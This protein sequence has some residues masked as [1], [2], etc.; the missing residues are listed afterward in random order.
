MQ[1][2]VYLVVGAIGIILLMVV[3]TQIL[4]VGIDET[5]P[6]VQNS[7]EVNATHNTLELMALGPALLPLGLFLVA[8]FSVFLMF[9]GLKP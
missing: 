5:P 2:Y 6:E 4:Q 3:G 1:N 8:I 7:S 9:L